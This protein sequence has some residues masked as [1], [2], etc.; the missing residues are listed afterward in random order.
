MLTRKILQLLKSHHIPFQILTKNGIDSQRDFDIYGPEDAFAVTL[1]FINDKQSLEYE[2]GAS[3]P[4]QRIEAL[5]RAKEVNIHTWVSL[6]PVIDAEQSLELI[7]QTYSSVDLYKIGML[8]YSQSS[9]SWRKFGMAAVNLCRELKKNYFIKSE[10]NEYLQGFSYYNS[11]NR[12]I[13]RQ[14]N[15]PF[16]QMQLKF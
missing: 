11:D 10:L 14:I 1:T 8:N 12:K 6:E 7:R 2:P 3:L 9:I 16:S 15:K 5:K 4:N 13:K